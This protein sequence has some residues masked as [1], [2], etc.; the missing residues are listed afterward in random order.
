MMPFLSMKYILEDPLHVPLTAV[1]P[2]VFA[3]LTF[4]VKSTTTVLLLMAVVV[5]NDNISV[6]SVVVSAAITTARKTPSMVAVLAI[7][8]ETGTCTDRRCPFP[9]FQR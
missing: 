7:M 2:R 6:V 3:L 5:R 9:G 1:K 8:S 4:Q